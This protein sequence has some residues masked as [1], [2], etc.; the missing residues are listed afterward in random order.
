MR[1]ILLPV[2]LA[3][4]L[5]IMLSQVSLADSP[6]T[7]TSFSEAYRDLPL[8]SAAEKTHAL[9]PA[10]SAFL[11]N[12]ATPLDQ[13]LALVNALGW[14]FDGQTNAK[15][16]LAAL[17][18]HYGQTDT[19]PEALP[20]TADQQLV[21]GY[22]MAMDN[23]LYPD[24]TA[25]PWI[26]RGARQLWQSES[27]QLVLAVAEGHGYLD[28]PKVWCQVWMFTQQALKKPGLQ[29]DMRPQ[30]REILIDYMRLYQDSCLQ[31]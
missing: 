31:K 30:G 21:L 3:L 28:R 11:L 25:L 14:N 19:R 7:S 20:L 13:K 1:K 15:V 24:G 4:S 17:N 6:L 8:V 12:Q 5:N 16:F 9:T 10:M 29:V 22:L 26:R 18:Q 27:A 2:L 23:Y